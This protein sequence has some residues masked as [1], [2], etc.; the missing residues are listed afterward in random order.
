MNF[1]K[2]LWKDLPQYGI[3]IVKCDNIAKSIGSGSMQYSFSKKEISRGVELCSVSAEGFKSA[4]VTIN[5]VMPLCDDASLYALV[6]NVLTRSSKQY[7]DITSIERKLAGLYGAELSVEVAK[8]G[9]HQV[10]KMGVSCIDDRFAFDGESIS[11]ECSKLLFE[12]VFNPKVN[13]GAFSVEDTESEKRLLAERLLA[14]KSDK[15]IYAKNRCEEEMCKDEAFGINRF[16]TLEA[17]QE[18]TPEGLFKAYKEILRKSKIAVCVSG[19][20]NKDLVCEYLEKYTREIDRELAESKTL[21][22]E[23]AEDVNYVKEKEAVKQGKLVM[24]F[25]LGMT[26]SND[27]YAARRVMADIFGGSPSSKLFTVVR[28]KMSLCYYC[29]ARMIRAKGVMFVQSGIESENEEKAKDAI[30]MQLEDIKNGN[31]TDEDMDASVKALE[32]SFKSVSD[33]PEALDAWFMSQCVSSAYNYPEDYI[34][35]FKSVTREDVI[36]AAKDVTLDTVFM[37]EGTGEGGEA[38]E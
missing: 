9:E 1:I 21:F 5:F 24:G 29:S 15:R 23:T 14:E 16:G 2:K 31:F 10:I 13:D 37:L 22:V 26:D 4:C 27:N 38:D 3:I 32:D 36:N 33:S 35:A 19:N 28:E 7:P 18:I 6:P 17:I 11:A 8:I 25:R 20:C 30:L 34:N 12:L